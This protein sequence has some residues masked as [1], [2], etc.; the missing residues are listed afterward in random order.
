M[1]SELFMLQNQVSCWCRPS[2]FVPM[3]DECRVVLLSQPSSRSG[4]VKSNRK[5]WHAHRW[6]L[7]DR[8]VAWADR[9]LNEFD[10]D[11]ID[12]VD[13]CG[14]IVGAVLTQSWEL[15][16]HKGVIDLLLINCFV[17]ICMQ[18]FDS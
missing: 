7:H 18:V 9:R 4:D 15:F 12:W 6:S 3:D 16:S 5:S 8:G 1:H 13:G 14:G 17:L 11:R 10:V 2:C